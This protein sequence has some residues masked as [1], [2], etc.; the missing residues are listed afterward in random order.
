MDR[1]ELKKLKLYGIFWF[2]VLVIPTLPLIW[3]ALGVTGRYSSWEEIVSLWLTILPILILFLFH[4]FLVLPVAKHNR[5]LYA[6]FLIPLIIIFGIFCFTIGNRPP[7]V[8]SV[9]SPMDFAPPAHQPARPGALKLGFGVLAIL[10]N[11]GGNA[12]VE[13]EKKE[14]ERRVLEINNLQLQLEALRFQINPHFFLNTLNN[15]QALVLLDPEKATESIGTFSKMMQMILRYGNA[16]V[17]PLAD[18]VCFLECFIS[19]MRQR[20]TEN[21][22]IDSSLPEHTG[23]SVIQ[24]LILATF[25]ENAFKYGISYEKP[26]FIQIRLEIL[27]GKIVFRC[28]NSV[29]TDSQAKGYGI[30]LENTR[31]RLSLVYGEH[32]TLRTGK[33]DGCYEVE[34]AL[35]DKIVVPES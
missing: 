4:N 8:S 24:P 1:Y 35:P 2:S 21:V 13:R 34:L 29:S 18:E 27:E 19:L 16:P 11:I 20:Y 32:F 31:K 15:I 26:S 12:I 14:E 25:V 5:L 17:I 9:I 23:N 7:G 33:S 30:G 22:T 3:G 28:M 6:V 10:A